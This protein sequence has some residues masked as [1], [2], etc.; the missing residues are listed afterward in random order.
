[1]DLSSDW[2]QITK[3]A[4]LRKPVMYWGSV[5]TYSAFQGVVK[6]KEVDGKEAYD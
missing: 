4:M 3:T 6:E 2:P 1:M 5:V